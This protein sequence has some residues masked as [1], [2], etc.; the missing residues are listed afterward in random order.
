[1]PIKQDQSRLYWTP[2]PPKMD[3]PSTYIRSTLYPEFQGTM[4]DKD[5]E[6]QVSIGDEEDEDGDS[7]D[8]GTAEE[9]HEGDKII[10]RWVCF[11]DYYY[12]N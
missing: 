4:L 11:K 12:Y 10:M 2:A 8:G 9:R 1:M 6:Q 7:E 3:L 5:I